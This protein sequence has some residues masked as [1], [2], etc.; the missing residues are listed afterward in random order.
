MTGAA[1]G[2]FAQS[3]EFTSMSLFRPALR[4][5]H[6]AS[7]FVE[8]RPQHLGSGIERLP[9]RRQVGPNHGEPSIEQ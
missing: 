8:E 3:M 1:Q 5:D 2:K 7:A 6:G 4:R 9:P